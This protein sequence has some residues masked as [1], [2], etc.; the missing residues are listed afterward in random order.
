MIHMK[1]ACKAPCRCCDWSDLARLLVE[2]E[3]AGSCDTNDQSFW[4]AAGC[5]P[6][7]TGLA[8]GVQFYQTADTQ[9][10]GV[11]AGT[12]DIE[13]RHHEGFNEGGEGTRRGSGGRV[14]EQRQAA[15]ERPD[16]SGRRASH[17]SGRERRPE[18]E[19]VRPEDRGHGQ[20]QG[21]N[22][23]KEIADRC[24]RTVGTDSNSW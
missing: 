18:I 4:S 20:T 8:D 1:W 19:G 2:M 17:T 14:D 11:P 3:P 23:K 15:C 10:P 21:H 12:M 7:R 16:E 22:R 5:T 6:H 24:R 13:R 9:T